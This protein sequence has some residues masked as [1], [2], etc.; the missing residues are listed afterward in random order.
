M[1]RMIKRSKIVIYLVVSVA[2]LLILGVWPFGVI[3]R[4]YK[5][6]STPVDIVE[7]E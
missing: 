2:I 6:A 7:A 5:T 4:T 1:S 3:H